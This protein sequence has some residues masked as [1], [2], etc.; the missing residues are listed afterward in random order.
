MAN[1]FV[2]RFKGKIATVWGGIWQS[3]IQ[4]S[5]VLHNAGAPS[6]GT[7]GTGAGIAGPGALLVDTTNFSV[8]QN[9]NTLASPTWTTIGTLTGSPSIVGL[10]LS[11]LLKE[12]V[13]DSITAGATQTQAGATALTTEVNRV[14]TNATA[15]NGVKLMA[16]VAG[17]TIVVINATANAMQ[18]YGAGSDTINGATNTVGV[19]QMAN[20]VVLYVCTTAG[21]W[22]TEGL[23][24]GF[25]GSNQTFSFADA[26]SANS[27]GVQA[28]AT[29]IVTSIARFT[30]VGGAGYSSVLPASAPGLEITV[31]NAAAANAMKIFPAGSDAIDSLGAS[32][33]LLV[34]AGT[35]ATFY[36][37]VAGQW[38]T[39]VCQSSI[40]NQAYSTNSSTSASTV[41]VAA[42][43]FGGA[44]EHT[45][46]LTGAITVASNAQMPLATALIAAIPNA[47]AG[48]TYKLR[49]INGG[50]TGSGVWTV[51]TNV[52]WTL[53]GT[54]TIAASLG[55]RDFYVTLTSLAAVVLQSLGSGTIGAI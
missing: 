5:A 40:V 24:T 6:N 48:N 34:A 1:G 14:S 8:Y 19:S 44:T 29:A 35:V 45:L 11:G 18:V 49:I 42:D 13:T 38:H 22:L 3:G 31:I 30:T 28:G 17:L 39:I 54:M 43:V 33:A 55:Y 20:S 25:S 15:G 36:C 53:T 4:S 32:A 52:G 12:S 47:R 23:G 51:T 37:T 50:G 16:S 10:T 7:T 9:T 2:Q 46:N 26:L 41:L 27:G 21:V